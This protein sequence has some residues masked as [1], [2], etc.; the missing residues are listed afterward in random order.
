MRLFSKSK[1]V[2]WVFMGICWVYVVEAVIFDCD[3]GDT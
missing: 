3:A 2:R 1:G